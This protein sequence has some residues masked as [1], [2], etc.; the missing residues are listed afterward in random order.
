MTLNCKRPLALIILDGWGVSPHREGNALAMA[1]TPCYDELCRTYP[2]TTLAASG[3][4]VGLPAGEPGNAESGH[5]TIGAGRIVETEAATIANAVSTGDFLKND[6]LR[7]ALSRAGADGKVVHFVGLLGDGGVHSSQETLFALL[8]MARLA[9]VRDAFVHG[10]LDGR[11]VQPRTADIY[12]DALQIKMADIGI[13]QIASLC[14]RFYAMDGSEH[15]ERTARAY[16]MLVHGEGE[17]GFDPVTA[18]RASFLRGITD[19]F[20]SPIVIERGGDEPVATIREADLVIF[21]NHKGDA[22]KQLV[23]SIAVPDRATPKPRPEVICLT[24]YDAS[25]DL[26]VAFRSAGGG[27]FLSDVLQREGVRNYRITETSRST[28]VSTFFNGSGMA[29]PAFER[30]LF[31]QPPVR[32]SFEAGPESRSFKIADAVIRGLG[33][34]S[35]GVFVVNMPAP[36][37]VADSGNL[38]RTVES[39]QFVDTCLGGVLE[40]LR[41]VNGI[42]LV[43]AS[44]TGCER[45]AASGGSA[46]P[47]P[48]PLHLVDAASPHG[49]LM[50]GGSLAD[51]APTMLGLKGIEK[52]A[53]MAGSDLRIL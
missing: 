13:G 28:H 49:G 31:L 19:E 46:A 50:S 48:V 9:G 32:D 26:P 8:R 27:S 22:M 21:F 1:N 23:R 14:G 53:E 42:A 29:D 43:T 45:I 47:N 39:V 36:A 25:F 44:H 17:R 7:S 34:D 37:M 38:E 2:S 40:K 20:I 11:D 33:A 24:E 6:V 10:I 18:I 4:A 16:T 12:V 3:T 5:R 35:D 51:I 30:H 15:W 52:P 41:E